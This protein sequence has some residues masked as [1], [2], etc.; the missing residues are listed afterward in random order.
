MAERGPA[1]TRATARPDGL[2]PDTDHT[3]RWTAGSVRIVESN[4]GGERLALEAR[5]SGAELTAP[6]GPGPRPG[7]GTSPGPNP[8]PG[9]GHEA[10]DLL[11]VGW[12][13]VDLDR[14]ASESTMAAF[15]AAPDDPLLGAFARRSVGDARLVLLEPNTEGRLSATLAKWGEGPVALYLAAHGPDRPFSGAENAGAGVVST[16]RDGPFGPS[17]I[18]LGGPITGPYVIVAAG[19]G[20]PHGPDGTIGLLRVPSERHTSRPRRSV[21]PT[22]TTPSASR[23]SSRTRATRPG[24]PTSSPARTVLVGDVGGR[25]GGVRGRDTRLRRGP[26][27]AAL[28]ARRPVR[29][30]RRPRR[31]RRRPGAGHRPS[32]PRRG[33][34][35]SPATP[36]RPSSRRPPDTTGPRRVACTRPSATTG[37]SPRTSASGCDRHRGVGPGHQ[38]QGPPQG[39]RRRPG[40][41]WRLVRGPPGR[42]LRH[43]RTERRGQDD[44][45]RDAR[46]PAGPDGGRPRVL[47]LD[48]SRAGAPSR[49]ASGC[50]SRPRRC[51]RT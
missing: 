47:G 11:A 21:P 15:E 20:G 19:R 8:G 29:P 9:P 30:G 23:R 40:R 48:A 35:D 39:V 12:A 50:S 1:G 33:R 10:L 44:H 31:R 32:P 36:V 3:L 6:A 24:R 34:S 2:V 41:R 17:V 25:R 37:A 22:P 7:P 28:R 51:I 4:E 45:G 43:A 14:A 46:R 13:T 16:G 42:D 38:G 27:R 5:P 18:L 49:S 26:S